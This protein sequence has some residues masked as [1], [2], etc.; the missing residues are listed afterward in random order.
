[1][2][3]PG[4]RLVPPAEARREG[5]FRSLHMHQGVADQLVIGPVEITAAVEQ[6]FGHR[7][8]FVQFVLEGRAYPGNQRLHLRVGTEHVGEHRHQAVLPASHPP[9]LDLEVHDA[10]KFSVGAGVG[11]QGH[12]AGVLHLDRLRHAIVGVAAED[13]VDAGDAA[14]QLQVHVH[15]I[16]R[17]HHDYLGAATAGFVDEF[18]HG[19]VA[20]AE[21]PVRHHPARVGDRRIGEGL[22]DDGHLD[23]VDLADDVGLE[24]LV[25]EVVGDHVLGD[26]VDAR[27][28]EVAV[29]DFLDARGA[30]GHL[31]VRCHDVHAQRDTRIDHVL[32]I[33]PQGRGGA[34]PG[35]AAIEQQGAR[36]RSAHLVDQGLQVREAAHLAVSA[37]GGGEIEIAESV[38]VDAAS[39]DVV[40]L[41]QMLAHQVRHAA[42]RSADAQV[43]VGLAE[44]DRLQL[45]VAVGHVHQRHI[46]EGRQIVIM[47]RRIA[48]QDRSAIQSK[49][50]CGGS[51][52]NLQK[53][54]AIHGHG[55]GFL[56][57]REVADSC[58]DSAAGKW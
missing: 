57:G 6:V 40:G 37:G 27:F 46:A 1:M 55:R 49:A 28:L 53:F 35:V 10:Q 42:H 41:Q 9:P 50:G 54:A 2:T 26:E 29:D 43:H 22:A 8:L 34:L 5:R 3:S 36:A 21:G 39:L 44:I 13:G 38:C 20:Y 12:A 47:R 14:G 7:Q 4:S 18:L 48:G 51:G 24:H 25:A 23:T 17:Q 31:P 58:G 30:V 45:R 15:A 19:I 56:G 11:H 33:G 52:K 32:G 16:V